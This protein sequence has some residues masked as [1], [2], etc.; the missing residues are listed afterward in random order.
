MRAIAWYRERVSGRTLC[1][2]CAA[3][4]SGP[5]GERVPVDASAEDCARCGRSA[6]SVCGE[7]EPEGEPRMVSGFLE[8]PQCPCTRQTERYGF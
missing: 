5:W 3:I 1:A 8:Y 6:C 2:R 7:T 4:A